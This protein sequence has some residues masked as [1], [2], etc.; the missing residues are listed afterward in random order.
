MQRNQQAKLRVM[1]P[2]T[3]LAMTDHLFF[4]SNIYKQKSDQTFH[5]ERKREWNHKQYDK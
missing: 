5:T 3:T 1:Y 2:Q 4:Q